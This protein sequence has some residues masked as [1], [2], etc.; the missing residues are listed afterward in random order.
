MALVFAPAAVGSERVPAGRCDFADPKRTLRTSMND[1]LAGTVVVLTGTMVTVWAAR[2]FENLVNPISLFVAAWTASTSLFLLRL[3]PYAPL[4]PSTVAIL[5][6]SGCCFIG[7]V[8][9]SRLPGWQAFAAAAGRWYASQDVAA[10]RGVVT[11]LLVALLMLEMV[12]FSLYLIEVASRMAL[13]SFVTNLMAVRVL[14][15]ELHYPAILLWGGALYCWILAAGKARE[16]PG[17]L[18]RWLVWAVPIAVTPFL[19]TTGR[20]ELFFVAITAV[21][22]RFLCRGRFSIGAYELTIT[23]TV[24]TL[25]LAFF[26]GLSVLRGQVGS[27]VALQLGFPSSLILLVDPYLYAT[28]G[29]AAFDHLVGDVTISGDL[30]GPLT[31]WPAHRLLYALGAGPA[32]V[33]WLADFVE[34]PLLF[35]TFTYLQLYLRDYGVVGCF[36]GS[37][38]L[39]IIGGVLHQ[40]AVLGNTAGARI[41]YAIFAFAVFISP[42]EN[43]FSQLMVPL[44]IVIT[45]VL[46]WAAGAISNSM[47][48]HEPRTLLAS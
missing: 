46:T 6:A 18:P 20:G 1:L 19:M 8:L 31:F 23:A 35:N 48:S 10:S 15:P 9:I 33:S 27:H 38:A 14:K 39:G 2:R 7:G 41:P 11:T 45:T 28:G 30:M 44:L 32:P 36:V 40:I 25:L 47:H 12:S 37:L 17:N 34:I 29:I 21:V 24:G 42:W 5:L 13:G 26:K 3:M 43:F 4:R 22:A 16:C